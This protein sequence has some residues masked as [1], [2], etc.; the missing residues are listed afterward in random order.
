[1]TLSAAPTRN[2]QISA[3]IAHKLERMRNALYETGA[4]GIRLRGTDWFSWAT[5]GATHTVLLAAETGVAEVLVTHS[6]AWILTNE[7]EA[8][9]LKDEELPDRADLVGGYELF[10]YPWIN[11]K[12][13]ESFI[14]EVT[15]RGMILSDKPAGST[16]DRSNEI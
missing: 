2:V 11:A 10:T 1:M 13:Q 12:F 6:G 16:S 8:Q 14:E 4:A 5:A 3:E 7:I 15:H 9:R